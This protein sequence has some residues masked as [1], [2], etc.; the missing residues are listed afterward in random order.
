[1]IND[2]MLANMAVP[3][4]KKIVGEKNVVQRMPGMSGEDF[5]SFT[6]VIPGF[7]YSLGSNDPNIPSGP[8]HN[9]TFRA[10]D[11]CLPIGIRAMSNVLLEFLKNGYK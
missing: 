6:D 7:F 11:S 2:S 9:P 5:S 8:H 4:L 1:M 10:E 3:G